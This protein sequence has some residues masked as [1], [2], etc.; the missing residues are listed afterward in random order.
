[1]VEEV[2]EPE[3][4]SQEPKTQQ[5][6]EA[7]E[8]LEALKALRRAA[9][10]AEFAPKIDELTR[11]YTVYYRAAVENL[12]YDKDREIVKPLDGKL[13]QLQAA[14]ESLQLEGV[15]DEEGEEESINANFCPPQNAPDAWTKQLIKAYNTFHNEQKQKQGAS[16]EGYMSG[17]DEPVQLPNGGVRLSFPNKEALE[18]FCLIQAKKGLSFNVKNG[19]GNVLYSCGNGVL[20]N[21]HG[22]PVPNP[23]TTARDKVKSHRSHK[24]SEEGEEDGNDDV[25]SSTG[26]IPPQ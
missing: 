1:M 17:Y 18:E 10:A 4:K 20:K 16:D 8:A 21:A 12:E 7:L 14:V 26:S 15:E 22:I 24:T 6:T 11:E 23:A 2:K 9:E 13:R 5:Q 25:Q 3:K 19:S